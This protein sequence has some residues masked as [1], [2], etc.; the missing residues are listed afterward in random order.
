M[1]LSLGRP[2]VTTEPA[3]PIPFLQNG[4]NIAI[5]RRDD[6]AAFARQIALLIRYEPTLRRLERGASEL[7][8]HFDWARIAEQ[9]I[10][11]YRAVLARRE[12]NV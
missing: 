1:S 12:K 7:R 9:Y 5:V 3:T 10:E 6:P 8:Q 11:V 2:V 4:H